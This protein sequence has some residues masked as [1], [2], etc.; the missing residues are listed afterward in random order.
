[1]A[2]AWCEPN[3]FNTSAKLSAKQTTLQQAVRATHDDAP[4]NEGWLHGYIRKLSTKRMSKC[5]W[6]FIWFSSSTIENSV[7][8][9]LILSTARQCNASERIYHVNEPMPGQTQVS[10]THGVPHVTSSIFL[11]WLFF[12]ASVVCVK[13]GFQRN[14]THATQGTQAPCVACVA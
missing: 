10:R 9:V 1:M 3:V 8:T 11:R 7:N 6:L 2:L 12:A 4:C 5:C 13:A 14:A